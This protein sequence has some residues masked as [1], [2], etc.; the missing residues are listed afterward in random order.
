MSW[1]APPSIDALFAEWWGGPPA[2]PNFRFNTG[3]A[4]NLVFGGNPVYQ[5]VDFL[6]IYPKFGTFAQAIGQATIAAPG[7]GYALGDTLSVTQLDASGSL[8]VVN[9]VNGSG[10]VTSFVISNGGKGYSV[11]S[12]LPT[13]TNHAGIGAT[14]NVTILSPGNLNVPIAVI[15]LYINLASA[16]LQY[17]RWLDTWKVG[18]GLFVAHFLTL[19]LQ[20]DGNPASS[21]GQI[22]TSGLARGIAVSKAAGDVSVS[23]E[24]L[25]KGM[26]DWGSFALTSYGQL[27]VTFARTLGQGPMYI[28]G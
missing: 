19:Y 25:L 13:T 4:S 21:A 9:A 16:S 11:A 14:V 12:A 6:S 20:S 23:Y 5:I 28:Y 1:G 22:A 15:Q 26:E 17:G 10:G 3:A 8:L 18:M 7:S 2:D 27:L 24:T